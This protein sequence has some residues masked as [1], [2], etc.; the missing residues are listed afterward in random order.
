MGD[1]PGLEVVGTYQ[2]RQD[3]AIYNDKTYIIIII[4]NA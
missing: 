4:T 1:D 3:D 2:A